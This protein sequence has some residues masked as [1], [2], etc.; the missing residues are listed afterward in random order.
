MSLGAGLVWR[1]MTTPCAWLGDGDGANEETLLIALT[2]GACAGGFN[3]TP[4]STSV[5][6]F[7][8][9]PTSHVLRRKAGGSALLSIPP[10]LISVAGGPPSPQRAGYARGVAGVV[11]EADGR[12]GQQMALSLGAV[13]A[14]SGRW[15]PLART[16]VPEGAR[17]AATS[18]CVADRDGG[19]SEGRHSAVLLVPAQGEGA[20]TAA[21]PLLRG[22]DELAVLVIAE[23]EAEDEVESTAGVSDSR[24][25]AWRAAEVRLGSGARLLCAGAAQG[26]AISEAPAVALAVAIP[27]PCDVGG[28]G[29]GEGEMKRTLRPLLLPLGGELLAGLRRGDPARW[30]ARA[31]AVGG[32]A[33]LSAVEGAAH[34]ADTLVAC[35][36]GAV[37]PSS[38]SRCGPMEVILAA[39]P[40]GAVARYGARRALAAG[41]LPQ[42]RAAA[43]LQAVALGGSRGAARRRRGVAVVGHGASRAA[44]LL[45]AES[46]AP[47]VAL[48]E[49]VVAL[50]PALSPPPAENAAI[51][52][53]TYVT[54][55][56]LLVLREAGEGDAPV[57]DMVALD[58]VGDR[59]RGSGSASGASGVC[60]AA[61]CAAAGEALFAA[62]LAARRDAL[63]ERLAESEDRATRKRSMLRTA[64]PLLSGMGAGA[65]ENAS[66]WVKGVSLSA[67]LTPYG[68][69]ELVARGTVGWSALFGARL[70]ATSATTTCMPLA[71]AA[72]AVPS[73]AA[74]AAFELRLVVDTFEGRQGAAEVELYLVAEVDADE[75]QRDDDPLADAGWRGAAKAAHAARA[76]QRYGG[77]ASRRA[78]SQRLGLAD[79]T[80][81]KRLRRSPPPAEPATASATAAADGSAACRVA[82]LAIRAAGAAVADETAAAAELRVARSDLWALRA[83]TDEAIQNA[84]RHWKF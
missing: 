65:E 15:A 11:V 17:V 34:E 29:D 44:W 22:R 69:L 64:G 77:K 63:A 39:G 52:R 40:H 18:L 28:D 45:C 14:R 8:W 2:G 33:L 25:R 55:D 54:Y 83:R 26:A 43:A 79:A 23:A 50:L 9:T 35:L 73:L 7:A 51:D 81:R 16:D 46:L 42:R 75:A 78:V 84:A 12:A 47:L 61:A 48:G 13:D 49:G 38:E 71:G 20:P 58:G 56:H 19:A 3:G 37:S 68:R 30:F 74:E 72:T 62:T 66:T 80:Y 21:V 53:N 57:A 36:L 1:E 10:G 4:M 59:S 5:S 76:H 27:P 60:A 6:V 67:V 24:S 70:V 31:A 41:T 82:L 32:V